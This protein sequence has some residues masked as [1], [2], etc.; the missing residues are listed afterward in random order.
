[1]A[2]PEFKRKRS[3]LSKQLAPQVMETNRLVGN[4][5]ESAGERAFVAWLRTSLG[6]SDVLHTMGSTVPTTS[7]PP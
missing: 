1:M 6:E 5:R 2:T 4:V 7:S 3:Q